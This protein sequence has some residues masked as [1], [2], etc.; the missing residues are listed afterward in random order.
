MK[1]V[2]SGVAVAAWPPF[3]EHA[4]RNVGAVLD[5]RH[6]MTTA[7]LLQS[8]KLCLDKAEIVYDSQERMATR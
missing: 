3:A 2:E 5:Q 8:L 4:E 1:A 7:R 6:A